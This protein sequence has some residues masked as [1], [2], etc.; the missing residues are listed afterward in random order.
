MKKFLFDSDARSDPTLPSPE[1]LKYR[2]L[3][4]NKKKHS[5]SSQFTTA[6][7]SIAEG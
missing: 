7:S 5:V 1:D 3:L 6:V 2:I 4:K